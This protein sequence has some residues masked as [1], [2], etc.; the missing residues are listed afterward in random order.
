MASPRWK[1]GEAQ[2]ERFPMTSNEVTLKERAERYGRGVVVVERAYPPSHRCTWSGCENSYAYRF[3]FDHGL[4]SDNGEEFLCVEH[5]R[6]LPTVQP[7]CAD[8]V[9]QVVAND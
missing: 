6:H 8:L 9:S 4:M 1:N 3:E 7:E 5:A 2:G